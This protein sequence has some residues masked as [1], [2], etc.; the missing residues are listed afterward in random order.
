MENGKF[1]KR[2]DFLKT[3][4]ELI[5]HDD[6]VEEIKNF[7]KAFASDYILLKRV[8]EKIDGFQ[9]RLK[10]LEN[11]SKK[12]IELNDSIKKITESILVSEDSKEVANSFITYVCKY[13]NAASGAIFL[14][15]MDRLV[16][17]G[18]FA[19]VIDNEKTE[20]RFKEGTVGEVATQKE[21]ILLRGVKQMQIVT[22]F[23][24]V[25]PG[26]IYTFPVIFDDE[27][28]AVAE[29]A[30][31]DE[32]EQFDILFLEAAA[33]ILATGL[34]K[35][36][37]ML[38][39]E[40]N[41]KV[42]K[43]AYEEIEEK[44]NR[45]EEQNR[46]IE[47][48]KRELE[49][50]NREI[51][52]QKRE[53]E[54]Q[55]RE[56]EIASKELEEKNRTIAEESKKI[57]EADKYK[58]EFLA[59]MSHELR[60]PLNSIITLSKL[61]SNN[62]DKNLND[63]QLKHLNIIYKSANDLLELIND[64]LDLSKLEAKLLT[65][66]LQNFSIKDLILE[67]HELF[68]PLAQEKGLDFKLEIGDLKR[69]RVYSDVNKIKQILRNFI[70]NALK[71]SQEGS[72]IV[73]LKDKG[74]F[75]EIF[76]KDSGIGIAKENLKKIFEPFIQADGSTNRKYGGT[77]LGLAITKE[78]A[79]LMGG[80]VHVESELGVGSCFS[81]ALPKE[82]K[83]EDIKSKGEVEIIEKAGSSEQKIESSNA[84]RSL[85]VIED[86]DSALESL[87]KEFE[88]L[89]FDVDFVNPKKQNGLKVDKEYSCI[90]VSLFFK[91][92]KSLE[93]V[94]TVKK[95]FKSPVVIYSKQEFTPEQISYLKAFSSEIIIQTANSLD[96]LKECIAFFMGDG[97]S[98]Q[99][100]VEF[101]NIDELK[102]EF[103]SLKGK[104]VL[105][106]DDDSVSLFTIS[107]LLSEFEIDSIVANSAEETFEKLK[108]QRVDLV[109][110]DIM[111]PN[112][113]GFEA[114]KEI[115]RDEKFKN[116][117]I[118]VLTAKVQD[119]DKKSAI[120]AGANDFLTKPLEQKKLLNIFK[121]LIG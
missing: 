59:N 64:I 56:L 38:E 14:V 46:E 27:L 7:K 116:L 82:L 99:R 74:D 13:L 104:I 26:S 20:F 106:T 90:V 79:E 12:F 23:S 77:G 25:T 32:F 118:V 98:R 24:T 33:D 19:Y 78:L 35:N 53:L 95:R 109:L 30:V 39:L 4:L 73:G 22:S 47:Q 52:Q 3:G 37:K 21:P 54:R 115:R 108:E 11:G 66:H 120:D 31:L 8:E 75:F 80:E 51:E 29:V 91:S 60:T 84:K 5:L 71:F 111:M 83:S 113:D 72:V 42:L 100:L 101:D 69:L 63:K 102:D 85:L 34:L 1:K 81:V 6:R 16:L 17:K 28:L 121:T 88:S 92:Q 107:T 89:E 49:E 110:M 65:L 41:S 119:E 93:F 117:P 44:A 68:L 40:Q 114:I 97:A 112:I 58:S 48:Q 10:D 45:V 36:K 55:N 96:R 18:S 62:R 103:S 9:Y 43:F 70:S 67:M 76:V 61:L 2:V 50:Q 105:I 87:K 57:K 94:E 15:E 86:D